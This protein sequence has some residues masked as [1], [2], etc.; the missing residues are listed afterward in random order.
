[1]LYTKRQVIELPSGATPVDFAY[2]V[3]PESAI[4]VFPCRN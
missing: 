3:H 1:M 2:V 4:P